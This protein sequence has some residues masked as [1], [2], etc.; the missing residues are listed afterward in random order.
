MANPIQ[1]NYIGPSMNPTL[2][3]VEI[4]ETIPYP[5]SKISIGDVAVFRLREE[6]PHV[7]HRVVVLGNFEVKKKPEETITSNL[8]PMLSS[9]V[10]RAVRRVEEDPALKNMRKAVLYHLYPED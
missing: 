1:I 4:L 9:S 7:V 6:S 5:G 8:P 2:K 3:A 10:S